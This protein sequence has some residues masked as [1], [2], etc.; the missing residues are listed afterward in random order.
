MPV[1]VDPLLSQ[2]GGFAHAFMQQFSDPGGPGNLDWLMDDVRL[3][4]FKASLT[5]GVGWPSNRPWATTDASWYAHPG[6]ADNAD[7]A[8]LAHGL[9]DGPFTTDGSPTIA[10]MPSGAPWYLNDGTVSTGSLAEVASGP[11][12][13][14]AGIYRV[15]GQVLNNT[16]GATSAQAPLTTLSVQT[17]GNGGTHQ[18][19]I[20]FGIDTG[21]G[22][23]LTSWPQ[24]NLA[25]DPA[26]PAEMLGI[27]CGLVWNNSDPNDQALAFVNYGGV[28]DVI[29]GT[30]GVVW[31]LGFVFS[32]VTARV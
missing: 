28:H 1:T 32:L 6:G 10:S 27:S 12:G 2:Q 31:Y 8:T 7:I 13:A 26:H 9:G 3:A 29:N 4:C 20:R 21:G 25:A 11:G 15:G 24:H 22:L 23:P 17:D 5:D 19:R 14:G 18:A 30:F 16:N